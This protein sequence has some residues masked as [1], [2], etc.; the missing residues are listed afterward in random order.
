MVVIRDVDR[1]VDKEFIKLDAQTLEKRPLHTLKGI[2]PKDNDALR[3]ALGVRTI[4]DWAE[5]PAVLAAQKIDAAAKREHSLPNDERSFTPLGS[6]DIITFHLAL[7]PSDEIRFRWSPRRCTH[8]ELAKY[9]GAH[10]HDLSRV[11][12]FAKQ[13]GLD[14]IAVHPQRRTVD[15]RGPAPLVG[16]LFGVRLG[17]YTRDKQMYNG[18]EGKHTIPSALQGI[19]QGVFGLDARPA[20]RGNLRLA[21]HTADGRVT[22][23]RPEEIVSKY[24]FVSEATGKG[25]TIGIVALGGCYRES[26]LLEYLGVDTR[27]RSV[28]VVEIDGAEQTD[29]EDADIELMMDVEIAAAIAPSAK[30]VIYLAPNTIKGLVDAISTAIHDTVHRPNILSMSWGMAEDG[31][32]IDAM[33]ELDRVFQTAASLGITVMA[34]SGDNGSS[35]GVDDDRTHVDFPASSPH[36]TACGGTSLSMDSTPLQEV[37]WRDASDGHGSG[38]GVSNVFTRPAWQ[39][40]NKVPNR[41]SGRTGR[42]LPDLGAH[43]DPRTG[44][45]IRVRGQDRV[46]GG[47]SA[48]APLMAALVARI[49]EARGPRG[50]IGF[51]NPILYTL[52]NDFVDITEGENGRFR[53]QIGWDPCTGLGRPSGPTWFAALVE[54]DVT[55]LAPSNRRVTSAPTENASMSLSAR[56]VATPPADAVNNILELK[57][58]EKWLASSDASVALLA[59]ERRSLIEALSRLC[60]ALAALGRTLDSADN[61]WST[62]TTASNADTHPVI[63]SLLQYLDGGT[64][65]AERARTFAAQMHTTATPI[66]DAVD[67]RRQGYQT[68]AETCR[69]DIDNGKTKLD[70][71]YQ[72]LD[73]ANSE[74]SGTSGFLHGLVTGLTLGIKNEIQEQIDDANAAIRD[75]NDDLSG[76]AQRS[77]Q[78]QASEDA[79]AICVTTL[80]KLEPF[81]EAV[82]S[83][84]NALVSVGASLR[85]AVND[86]PRETAVSGEGAIA[87]YHRKLGDEMANLAAWGDVLHQIN[88]AQG[89]PVLD[90]HVITRDRTEVM[91]LAPRALVAPGSAGWKDLY[92]A[93]QIQAFHLPVPIDAAIDTSTGV[94]V[95]RGPDFTTGLL[96][97]ASDLAAHPP[98]DG[99][100]W[101]IA[102]D[103]LRLDTVLTCPSLTSIFARRIE[104]T[105][106]AQLILGR[107]GTPS[108]RDLLLHVQELRD[109]A[110]MPCAL[111]ITDIRDGTELERVVSLDG[112]FD[113]ASVL[114]PEGG[115]LGGAGELDPGFLLDGEALTVFLAGL[116]QLGLLIETQRPTLALQQALWVNALGKGAETTR[117]MALQALAMANRLRAQLSVPA[118]TVVVPPLDP[119]VYKTDLSGWMAI[120]TDRQRRWEDLSSQRHNDAR[121]LTQA[122]SELSDKQDELGLATSLVQA[123]QH[124]KDAAESAWARGVNNVIYQRSQLRTAQTLFE[125]GIDHWKSDQQTDAAFNLLKHTATFLFDV[126]KL[127]AEMVV[128]PEVGA[129]EMALAAP[130]VVSETQGAVTAMEVLTATTRELK[131]GSGNEVVHAS[132]TTATRVRTVTVSPPQAATEQKESSLMDKASKLGDGLSTG[133]G[134]VAAIAGD[135]KRLVTISVQAGAL[136]AMG[137]QVGDS[138]DNALADTWKSVDLQGIDVVTGGKQTWDALQVKVDALFDKIPLYK[139]IDGGP[140]YRDA[141][142]L[143]L[144]AARASCD[145]R[146]AVAAAESRLSEAKLRRDTANRIAERA[147]Q[148]AG[149]LEKDVAWDQTIAQLVFDRVID[150]KRAVYL[151]SEQ[152][153]R[154][155]I[156]FA[157]RTDVPP[158]PDLAGSSDKMAAAVSALTSLAWKAEALD[159]LPQAMNKATFRVAAPLLKLAGSTKYAVSFEIPANGGDFKDYARVRFDR[160]RATLSDASGLIAANMTISLATSGQY[161]DQ[162]KPDD[163]MHFVA[164]P[165]TLLMKYV[166]S[167][168]TPLVDGSLPTG[169][170]GLY[171][172]PTPFTLWTAIIEATGPDG[173]PLDLSGAKL[174]LEFHGE[175]SA[176]AA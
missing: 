153:R 56:A 8:H 44:Y 30:I 53:A 79:S 50:S 117:T 160:V 135:I 133:A 110:D 146:L 31:W 73:H 54:H 102:C 128:A 52:G 70:L 10:E 155:L 104:V 161:V 113:A 59:D 72:R 103:V 84:Q 40:S 95:Q 107:T 81:V 141:F 163:Q 86:E 165:V 43:A 51:L 65:G 170:A 132:E 97:L 29:S 48:V 148:R 130:G 66:Q 101:V 171:F 100:A 49:N 57:F 4:R 121:W 23:Y 87:Y 89:D 92:S 108:G 47:T 16:R 61:T 76:L 93:T 74:M 68:D 109:E 139:D 120:L 129:P 20:A 46:A 17:K 9:H 140:A 32:T 96:L 41:V 127:V 175:A 64:T 69:Q 45:A 137:K 62:L 134:D 172:K 3:E 63:A 35:D 58:V 111:H 24:G 149:Q 138:V 158:L 78:L 2:T 42:G 136:H 143:L 88:P 90:A 147:K 26:D 115:E 169:L 105:K 21:P 77:A 168:A 75:I 98:A 99:N 150:A 145:T 6:E 27:A 38:G 60:G 167:E 37:A 13:E 151:L 144:V 55:N 7:R 125:S 1:I 119:E 82:T 122:T 123:A 67:K 173:K 39:R 25:Q 34:A 152:Y 114:W 142:R 80:Q 157:L 33:Q 131:L 126:G 83:L 28:A 106:N 12:A 22:G 156:Y 14:V 71:A 11:L 5:H 36:V 162:A 94:L 91:P 18:H 159:P 112:S 124:A 116:F 154:A 15:L 118:G 164:R 176:C 85:A 174:S 166:A 19:V